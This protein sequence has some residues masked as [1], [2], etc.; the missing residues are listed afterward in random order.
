MEMSKS[1]RKSNSGE[2]R[3]GLEEEW[4]EGENGGTITREA[5]CPHRE[6][7]KVEALWDTIR[8]GTTPTIPTVGCSY[9]YS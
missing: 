4:T 1:V 6:S 9:S 2:D 8:P 5:A 7:L 3:Q